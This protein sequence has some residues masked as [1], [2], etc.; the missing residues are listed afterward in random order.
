MIFP[1]LIVIFKLS[2]FTCDADELRELIIENSLLSERINRLER[3]ANLLEERILNLSLFKKEE[4]YKEDLEFLKKGYQLAS[5]R[6]YKEAITFLKKVLNSPRYA[7]FAYYNLGYV[8]TQ[9]EEYE[10]AADCF[11]KSLYF[12][13]DKDAYY[14]L[15][16]IYLYHLKNFKKAQ[17]YYRKY[18]TL[19]K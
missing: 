4:R 19:K 11:E 14:N 17:N 3:K 6:K 7:F 16:V 5:E 10:K 2:L 1:I 18:L 8:Y 13:E 12:R 9:L 15:V